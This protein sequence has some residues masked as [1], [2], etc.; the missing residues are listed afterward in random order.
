[1][2]SG[3][4]RS[5]PSRFDTSTVIRNMS[6]LA[7]SCTMKFSKVNSVLVAGPLF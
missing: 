7:S 2:Q 6:A 3:M 4:P 5:M 1:M